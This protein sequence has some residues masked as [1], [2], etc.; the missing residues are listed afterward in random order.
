MNLIEEIAR[1]LHQQETG[2]RYDWDGLATVKEGYLA[3]AKM[4]VE[5]VPRLKEIADREE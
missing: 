5:N 1:Q 4:L 3:R 2:G